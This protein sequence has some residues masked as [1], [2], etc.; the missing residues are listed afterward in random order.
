MNS[1][2]VAVVAKVWAHFFGSVTDSLAL[3]YQRPFESLSIIL[4]QKIFF[5]SIAL[6]TSP[7]S[8][9]VISHVSMNP[10]SPSSFDEI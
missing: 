4:A 7:I 6:N 2:L 3:N 1:L 8:S 5:S 9:S 10:Q